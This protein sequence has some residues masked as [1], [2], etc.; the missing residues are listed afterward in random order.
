MGVRVLR[1]GVW[2]SYFIDLSPEDM[3][4]QFSAKGWLESELSDEHGKML[5]DR[6][7]PAR[8]G[9]QFRTYAQDHGVTFPQGHLWLMCDILGEDQPEILDQLKK[10]LDLYHAI[11]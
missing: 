9:Q 6:G 7:E 11:G 4:V 3:V 5:L 10:W 1:V 2:S 8:V